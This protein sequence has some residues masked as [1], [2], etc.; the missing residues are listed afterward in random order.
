MNANHTFPQLN[1]KP[2]QEE[3]RGEMRFA[4]VTRPLTG[5]DLAGF[6]SSYN[7][8][9]RD[10]I[11]ALGIP[12]FVNYTKICRTT[13]ALPIEKELLIRLYDQYPRHAAWRT[14]Q[15]RQL[16][17]MLYGDLMSKFAGTE[18]ELPARLALYTRIMACFG[19]SASTAY[20]WF[21]GP[22]LSDDG[23]SEGGGR[24]KAEILMLM[25]LL[26]TMEN[27]RE[28]FEALARQTLAA[29]G[30]DLDTKYPLPDPS[31]P[32]PVRKPGRKPNPNSKKAQRLAAVAQAAAGAETES[33]PKG[34]VAPVTSPDS[35]TDAI[36]RAVKG[37]PKISAR[38]SGKILTA[39]QT[40]KKAPVAKKAA[41]KAS[42]KKAPAGKRPAT[43][44]ASTKQK[45]K[46]KA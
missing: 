10:A 25:N 8:K 36:V 15:P 3:L 14:V 30:I 12:N 38:A 31:N 19:R 45:T 11:F 6:H 42:A 21:E 29:R 43:K 34:K 13:D 7:I 23:E 27:P 18:H 24:A 28:V 39:K 2:R 9:K 5:K 20:R 1:I 46:I 32:P 37:A 22:D 16:F 40:T 17:D 26:S 44:P 4:K 33:K 35:N 41:P